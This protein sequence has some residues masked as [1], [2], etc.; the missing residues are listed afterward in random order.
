MVFRFSKTVCWPIGNI[1]LMRVKCTP[2]KRRS[3]VLVNLV[4]RIKCRLVCAHPKATKMEL[5]EMKHSKRGSRCLEPASSRPW[6][7]K[8]QSLPFNLPQLHRPN[9]EL[10]I[11]NEANNI[12]KT[13]HMENT[14]HKR[15]PNILKIRLK[16]PNSRASNSTSPAASAWH[17]TRSCKSPR[18][19]EKHQIKTPTNL[20]TT[21]IS[22][23]TMKA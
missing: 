23:L 1:R 6:P 12:I 20:Q 16:I 3:M 22:C 15:N 7:R 13:Y 17:R 4:T 14:T 9:R 21:F 10:S 18:I 8:M 19:S 2:I 11:P 5:V